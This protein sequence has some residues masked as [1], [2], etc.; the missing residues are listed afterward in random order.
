MKKKEKLLIHNRLTTR[1]FDQ[2][3]LCPDEH[4]NVSMKWGEMVVNPQQHMYQTV[5]TIN[6][7]SNSRFTVKEFR[8]ATNLDATQNC[9][10]PI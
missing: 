7:N 4:E 3:T 6:K 10:S 1:N 8:G 2:C 5:H 9:L